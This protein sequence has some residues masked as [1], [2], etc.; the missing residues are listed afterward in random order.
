MKFFA[1]GTFGAF[2]RWLAGAFLF[3]GIVFMLAASG[4]MGGTFNTLWE[5]TRLAIANFGNFLMLIGTFALLG[6]IVLRS[7]LSTWG[8]VLLIGGG[9][10]T[11]LGS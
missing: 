8:F 10:L 4:L 5:N 7:N 1:F 3:G 2:V 9:L 6:G 11:G